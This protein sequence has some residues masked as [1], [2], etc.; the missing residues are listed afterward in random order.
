MLSLQD[1]DD[2]SNLPTAI[3]NIIGQTHVFEIKTH[4]YYEY[5]SFESFTCWTVDPPQPV[6]ESACSST[7]DDGSALEGSSSKTSTKPPSV[8]TPT[9][10]TEGSGKKK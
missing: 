1:I 10:P 2:H 5:G 4:T 8:D 9:K 3:A 6:N 7:I